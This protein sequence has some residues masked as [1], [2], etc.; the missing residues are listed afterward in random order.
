MLDS[1]ASMYNHS[2]GWQRQEDAWDWSAILAYELQGS[3][4]GIAP[5]DS[6]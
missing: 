4:V 3:E 6:P 2:T 5:E 1:V